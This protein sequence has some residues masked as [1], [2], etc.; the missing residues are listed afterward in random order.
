MN[1][2]RFFLPT[3]IARGVTAP[4]WWH[5]MLKIVP[6]PINNIPIPIHIPIPMIRHPNRT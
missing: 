1:T 4:N 5:W 3:L 6:I 2:D